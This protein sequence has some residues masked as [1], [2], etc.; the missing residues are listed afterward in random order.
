MDFK[1]GDRYEFVTGCMKCYYTGKCSSCQ[2][3]PNRYRGAEV[4][5][6]PR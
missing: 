3:D 4:A 1:L 5:P 2:L 6:S